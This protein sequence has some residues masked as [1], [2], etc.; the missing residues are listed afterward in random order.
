MSRGDQ[1][2]DIFFNEVDEEVL[3]EFGKAWCLGGVWAGVF[4]NF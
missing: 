3:A 1:C 2:I 4:V